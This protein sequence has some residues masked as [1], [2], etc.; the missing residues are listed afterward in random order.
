MPTGG[1]FIVT[2]FNIPKFLLSG[3]LEP[4]A[5]TKSA[6]ITPLEILGIF[7]P[8]FRELPQLPLLS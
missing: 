7:S 4:I 3:L 2:V 1:G 8:S 5:D 6:F